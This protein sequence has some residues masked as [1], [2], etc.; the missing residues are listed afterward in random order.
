[1]VIAT[2]KSIIAGS[3]ES[4]PSITWAAESPTGIQYY[5]DI[6]LGRKPGSG[7][8]ITADS[9]NPAIC[10]FGSYQ[11]CNRNSRVHSDSLKNKKNNRFLVKI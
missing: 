10:S 7:I 5:V 8:V 1:V 4:K 3:V 2:I 6:G 11:I 9:Y